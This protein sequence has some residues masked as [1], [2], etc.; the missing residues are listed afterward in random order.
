MWKLLPSYEEQGINYMYYWWSPDAFNYRVAASLQVAFPDHT[1]HCDGGWVYN[2]PAGPITCDFEQY[3][4][5]KMAS[6]RLVSE[7]QEAN[8]VLQRIQMLQSD[9][10]ELMPLHEAAGGNLSSL[11][12]TCEFFSRN[13]AR[14]REWAPDCIVAPPPP[15]LARINDI[16]FSQEDGRCMPVVCSA[17]EI[18]VYDSEQRQFECRSCPPGEVP[19]EIQRRCMRCPLGERADGPLCVSCSIGQYSLAGSI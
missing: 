6:P 10:D 19:D 1:M 16:V 5:M 13:L 17:H 14:I 2:S 7:A 9:I 15:E 8:Y 3:R 11:E 18:I 12:L 4:L